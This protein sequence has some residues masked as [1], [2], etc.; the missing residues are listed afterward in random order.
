MTSEAT[1][2]KPAPAVPPARKRILTGERPTGSLHIGHYV[3]TLAN[4][5]R[6]QEQFETFLLVADYHMLTTRLE[7]LA[8]IKDNVRAVVLDNLSVGI[9]PEKVTI[10]LQSAVPEIP[11]LHLYFS[12]L[13][14]VPRVERIPTLKDQLRDHE[15]S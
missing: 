3:G 14:S 4:R 9:D 1:Q 12:M 8:E 11:Q 13:V 10:F 6:L 7:N 5:V 2:P 15:L